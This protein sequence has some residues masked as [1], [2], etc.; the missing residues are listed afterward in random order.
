[1]RRTFW[2]RYALGVAALGLGLISAPASAWCDFVTG[3]GYIITTADGMHAP[4]M[5]N[6][7]V[8]GGCKKN[9]PDAPFWGHLNYVDHFYSP[10]GHVQSLTITAYRAIETRGGDKNPK[11]KGTRDICGTAT[12]NQPLYPFVDFR[13]RVTDN[14]EPGTADIFMI[15]L[16]VGGNE[17]YSTFTD[18]GTLKGGNIQLHKPNPSTTETFF[19]GTCWDDAG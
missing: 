5:A 6:F 9:G 2:K 11:R 7:G 19:G 4:A 14:G 12:T 13:V 8:H 3:G 16:G 18:D 15:R 1:M 17:I 10:P